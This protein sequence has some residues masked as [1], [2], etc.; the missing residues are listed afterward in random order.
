MFKERSSS[1]TKRTW[2]HTIP[3]HHVDAFRLEVIADVLGTTKKEAVSQVIDGFLSHRRSDG[4][5]SIVRAELD[6]ERSRNQ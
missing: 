6:F 3:C 2:S 4:F 5:A 1:R